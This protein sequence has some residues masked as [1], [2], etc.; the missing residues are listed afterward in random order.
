MTDTA[1]EMIE[2]EVWATQKFRFIQRR[3][4]P[5]SQLEKYEAM[6]DA[7]AK[8]REFNKEFGD[9]IDPT[10]PYDWDDIDDLE[11]SPVNKAA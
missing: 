8:D 1:E 9:L 10:D 2:V 11:I 7:N 6:C 5:K 4:I 3:K